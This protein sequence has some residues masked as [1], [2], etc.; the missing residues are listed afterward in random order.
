MPRT[1]TLA[2]DHIGVL[3]ITTSDRTQLIRLAQ[4]LR[5]QHIDFFL[6]EVD[7][8]SDLD[9]IDYV[10]N[11]SARCPQYTQVGPNAWINFG[12]GR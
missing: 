1:Y 12:D 6:G 4:S 9:L 8:D 11:D 5:A 3:R 2:I 7:A 10:E